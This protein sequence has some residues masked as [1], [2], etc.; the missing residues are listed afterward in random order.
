RWA[1]RLFQLRWW[2]G[3][4]ALSTLVA[5]VVVERAAHAVCVAQPRMGR[6]HR[7][8]YL[9]RL[10][11]C[12]TRLEYV[13]DARDRQRRVRRQPPFPHSIPCAGASRNGAAGALQ[14]V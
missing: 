7:L 1:R 14:R 6:V 5:V 13:V 9:S 8:L 4:L 2:G 10:E 11:R 3:V 12:D